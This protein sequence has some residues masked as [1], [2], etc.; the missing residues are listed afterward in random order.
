MSDF[1]LPLPR[2]KRGGILKKDDNNTVIGVP[3]ENASTAAPPSLNRAKRRVSFAPEATMTT[4]ENLTPLRNFAQTQDRGHVA[5]TSFGGFSKP[6]FGAVVDWKEERERVREEKGRGLVRDK[7][8]DQSKTGDS[9]RDKLRESTVSRDS[10][11]SRDRQSLSTIFGNFRPSRDSFA[12]SESFSESREF[13][14]SINLSRDQSVR[15]TPGTGNVV[16]TSF[17]ELFQRAMSKSRESGARDSLLIGT[18]SRDRNSILGHVTSTHTL[19]EEDET[20]GEVDMELTEVALRDKSGLTEMGGMGGGS[21]RGEGSR[22]REEARSREET[23]ARDGSRE[24]NNSHDS[25]IYPVNSTDTSLAASPVKMEDDGMDFTNVPRAGSR[26][27]EGV[28]RDSFGSRG[29]S[30]RDSGEMDFTNVT[31]ARDIAEAGVGAGEMDF[32]NVGVSRGEDTGSRGDTVSRDR[33]GL[34]RIS[35]HDSD[36]MEYTSVSIPSVARIV[37]EEVLVRSGLSPGGSPRVREVG[38]ESMDFTNVPR[39]NRTTERTTEGS[40]NRG[41][42]GNEGNGGTEGGTFAIPSTRATPARPIASARGVGTPRPSLNREEDMS[43]TQ[44][45]VR[46]GDMSFTNVPGRSGTTADTPRGVKRRRVDEGEMEFTEVDVVRGDMSAMDS[47][48]E[49]IGARDTSGMDFTVPVPAV[50][51]PVTAADTSGMDFTGP[52]VPDAMDDG[53]DFTRPVERVEEAEEGVNMSFTRPVT[54]VQDTDMSFTRPVDVPQQMDMSFTRPVTVQ[55]EQEVEMSFTRPVEVPQETENDNMSFTRPIDAPQDDN[56]SFTRPVEVP[57]DDNMSFTRP[58]DLPQD[59]NMSFTRPVDVPGE[60]EEGNMS[61]TR[62]VDVPQDTDMSFTRPVDVQDGDM[63]FTNTNVTRSSATGT[64]MDFTRPVP[65]GVQVGGI[66]IGGVE[67]GGDGARLSRDR[68]TSRRTSRDDHSDYEFTTFGQQLDSSTRLVMRDGDME[69]SLEEPLEEPPTEDVE[70]HMSST[71]SHVPSSHMTSNHMTSNPSHV[72]RASL[73]RATHTTVPLAST[74]DR[75]RPLSAIAETTERE[76]SAGSQTSSFRYPSNVN[77]GLTVAPNS[78]TF[79]TQFS[80]STPATTNQQSTPGKRP[81]SEL[82]RD[83]TTPDKSREDE[84]L[85]PTAPMSLRHRFELLSTPRKV[86]VKRGGVGAGSTRIGASV[87]RDSRSVLTRVGDFGS[88]AI[89]SDSLTMTKFLQMIDMQFMDDFLLPGKR[90]PN[91]DVSQCSLSQYL[92]HSYLHPHVQLYSWAVEHLRK[93]IEV[94]SANFAQL[95]QE[96]LNDVPPIFVDYTSADSGVKLLLNKQFALDKQYYRVEARK[97]W[98]QWRKSISMDLYKRLATN[99]DLLR[100]DLSIID[101][102]SE[103]VSTQVADLKQALDT[104]NSHLTQLKNLS[105]DVELKRQVC[106]ELQDVQHELLPL[107]DKL[108]QV[109]QTVVE[110]E[111]EVSQEVQK[112]DEI[113]TQ[114]MEQQKR[115]LD[116]RHIDFREIE[117]LQEKLKKTEQKKGLKLVKFETNGDA[118]FESRDLTLTVSRESHLVVSISARSSLSGD[119]CAAVKLLS[120]G[121]KTVAGVTADWSRVNQFYSALDDILLTF[122]SRYQVTSSGQFELF[123]KLL[124]HKGQSRTDIQVRFPFA[125]IVNYP[126]MAGCHVTSKCVYGVSSGVSFTTFDSCLEVLLSVK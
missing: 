92:V 98:Y 96:T 58:V 64:G 121:Q 20:G 117:Q 87:S 32:T 93:D 29:S 124:T 107:V 40:G 81:F 42:E 7:A 68:R 120:L 1:T 13:E 126:N 24:N 39:S 2:R 119:K 116:N 12:A 56:M 22:S 69:K 112:Q 55:E 48:P 44:T 122:N 9:A 36:S 35:E 83:E 37:S 108:E 6:G 63:S 118:V 67:V 104:A 115:L 53:M 85:D 33:T 16:K 51:A 61:F 38:K 17:K 8:R 91:A 11:D 5:Q 31:L 52:V 47:V 57:Q 109:N 46:G 113:K 84:S 62:P 105:T 27:Q 97:S 10:R 103:T 102:D 34:S 77:S 18:S 101:R 125:E 106:S 66:E 50:S 73:S 110:L 21:S 14:G 99:R 26:D 76:D 71:S 79:G 95:D 41:T 86:K 78:G 28:A 43:F 90:Q 80:F 59:D 23:R 15:G 49:T 65:G 25:N 60:R 30:S 70:S 94:R 72:P 88:P 100:S 89:P 82:S 74:P 54:S 4:F 123:I 75:I 19:V 45:N 3:F 111:S 114:L